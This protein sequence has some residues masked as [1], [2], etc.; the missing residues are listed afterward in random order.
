LI[1]LNTF[2]V[3]TTIFVITNHLAWRRPAL[4]DRVWD[5][6]ILGLASDDGT[7][8]EHPSVR[9]RVNERSWRSREALPASR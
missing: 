2:T 3:A 1:P 9:E 5:G 8:A 4:L 6:M 7:P